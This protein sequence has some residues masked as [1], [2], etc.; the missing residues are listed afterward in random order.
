LVRSSCLSFIF[1]VITPGT[2]DIFL[3]QSGEKKFRL[4]PLV[5]A[6]SSDLE[7]QEY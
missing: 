7:E 2:A 6:I 5:R 3:A 4:L 1:L